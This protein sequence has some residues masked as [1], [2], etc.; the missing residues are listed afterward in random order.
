MKRSLFNLNRKVNLYFWISFVFT[1]VYITKTFPSLS[2]NA[3][4]WAELATNFYHN[5]RYSTLYENIWAT[6]AGYLP[7]LQRFI[8]VFVIKVFKMYDYF[9]YICQFIGI[10]FISFFCSF[11][12]LFQF[13]KLIKMDSLRFFVSLILGLGIFSTY[14][15]FSFINF[16]YFGIFFL[17]FSFFI[18]KEKFKPISFLLFLFF[19]VLVVNSKAFM[20]VTA[21]LFIIFGVISFFKKRYKETLYNLMMILAILLQITTILENQK[22]YKTN[23]TPTNNNIYDFPI[24]LVNYFLSSIL[25]ITEISSGNIYVLIIVLVCISLIFFLVLNQKKWNVFKFI[26]ICSTISLGTLTVNLVSLSSMK[27]FSSFTLPFIAIHRNVFLSN[28]LLWLSLIVLLSSI[29]LMLK[30]KYKRV[31]VFILALIILQYYTKQV[32]IR[33]INFNPNFSYSQWK[34]YKILLKFDDYC[35]PVNPFP[36]QY[37]KDCMEI[38]KE[39]LENAKIRAIIWEKS[40]QE[41]FSPNQI[42]SV[43]AINSNGQEIGNARLLNT[44]KDTMFNYYLFEAP[45]TPVSFK[46]LNASNKEISI[47][48]KKIK[49]Y[50]SLK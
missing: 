6:D 24:T 35:L 16:S 37:Q 9:P 26:F 34:D 42:H 2:Y 22:I 48:N 21:P 33:N 49:F 27:W 13:R 23:S 46:L 36:W 25:R 4:I 38:S 41:I 30:F 17:V 47:E 29:F 45:L 28:Y 14:E 3:E 10:G 18:E 12:N 5:A 7:W 43:V 50:G 44:I 15:D 31:I 8:A 39:Q 19:S 20:I 11:I 1:F 32:K 40:F